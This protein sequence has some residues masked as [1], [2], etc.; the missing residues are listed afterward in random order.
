MLMLSVDID[1]L[2]ADFTEHGQIDHLAVDPRGA[3]PL[4]IQLSAD[5]EV[6]FLLG[7]YAKPLQ[8]RPNR[9]VI[10]QIEQ[11][12]HLGFLTAVANGIRRPPRSRD[13]T[14]RIDDNRFP[15]A[16]LASKHMKS[17]IKMNINRFYNRQITDR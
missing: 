5:Y 2:L 15:R 6:L 13:H 10:R 4:G 12:F 16:C 8:R 7:P 11:G 17:G 14:Q 9:V 1:K 3:L